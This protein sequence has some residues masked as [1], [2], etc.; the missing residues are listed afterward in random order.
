MSARA[1]SAIIVGAGPSGIAMAYKLKHELGFED[2]TIYDKMDGVGGTWR[3]NSYPGCGCDVQSTL[4]SFSFNL[5]PNWSK[6]LAEQEE[7]LQYIEDTVD[8]F[9][10]RPHINVSVECTGAKWDATK[11]E[12][13]V[14]LKDLKTG[15]NF[16]RCATM[17]ISAVG[18]ISVPR[19]VH[20]EGMEAFKGPI[21]HT[22]QWRHDV[23]YAGKRVAVI[24]NGCSAVQVVPALAEKATSV[25]QYAR[26]P[27]WYHERPNRQFTS[28]E[29]WAFRTFPLIMRLRR[30]N[31]FWTIDKQ[32][33]AYRGTE[34]GVA[35]RLKEE[36]VARQYIQSKAPKKYH[37]ILTPD[38]ELGCKRKIA[39]PGYLEAL[40][41]KNI[42]L[43]PEG[44]QRIT[45]KGII[46]SSGREDEYDIIILATG[47]KV[48]QFLTP[49]EITGADGNTLQQQWNECR[50]AQAYLGTFVHNFPN[51]AI[52]FGP[53]TFPANNSALYACE[54]QVDYACRALVKPI[55]DG[56]ANVLEVKETVENRTTNDIHLKLRNSVFAGKCTNWYIG[57]FGRNTA[58]W[59]GM[60][61][62]FWIAT[63]IPNRE[64]FISTGGSKI[65][66][67]KSFKRWIMGSSL[68][69]ATLSS[70]LAV[71]GLNKLG[72]LTEGCRTENKQYDSTAIAYLKWSGYQE[73]GSGIQIE[74]LNVGTT[75][76]TFVAA[77]TEPQQLWDTDQYRFFQPIT[78]SQ[79]DFRRLQRWLS[80][81]EEEH[82][83]YRGPRRALGHP[84]ALDDQASHTGLGEEQDLPQLHIA[85]PGLEI[86]RFIDVT[87]KCLVEKKQLHRYVTLSYVWGAVASFKLS[88]NNRSRLMQSGAIRD[89]WE[90]IPRTLQDAIELTEKLGE[91][92]LWIDSLCLVQND[93]NDV[94]SGTESMDLIYEKAVLTIVAAC[95]KD[96]NAG[97]PGVRPGSRFVSDRVVEVKPGLSLS[98]YTTLDY[99][100]APTMYHSRAWT[101]Q[102]YGLS[103][104]AVYFV[105]DRV[106]FRCQT[107]IHSENYHDQTSMK[108]KRIFSSPLSKALVMKHPSHD[109]K[110]VVEFYSRRVLTYP[111]DVENALTGIIRRFS[112]R[113]K[114][115]FLCGLPTAVFDSHLLFRGAA[116]TLKRRSGFPS[117]SWTG[118]IGPLLF[119]PI[120]FSAGV[121]DLN[122]HENVWLRDCTWIR[123]YKIRPS[124]LSNLVWDPRG[125]VD[126]PHESKA[127]PG[128]RR[129]LPFPKI[130]GL[131]VD[132]SITIPSERRIKK[133][134]L[135]PYPMLQFWSLV[136]FFKI[137]RMDV[138]KARGVL[139]DRF[140]RACGLLY[141][142]G[143]EE[144]NSL[145]EAEPLELVLL[146]EGIQEPGI[147]DLWGGE[148]PLDSRCY[149]V[150]HLEW[151]EGV[152]E[153]RGIG[154]LWPNAITRSFAPGP[155][156]KEIILG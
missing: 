11:W 120:K 115:R 106:Y 88:R 140:G 151:K 77:V 32:S 141:I 127:H 128:Y 50:G 24:G 111:E 40:N 47:F 116:M 89:V 68:I 45:D 75:N 107:S 144:M 19:E 86:I 146:S 61:I 14:H 22:A 82:A 104:R 8:K 109:F 113:M 153:R 30:W 63:L 83:C 126:F 49:M 130:A 28:F 29:K 17:F 9:Q 95:G 18:G 142:D 123:W 20:F 137:T 4:Y 35:Q 60:A 44:I 54:V 118:W 131:H 41:R 58:S 36:E 91:R 7:I 59:P 38:F 26:S 135:R 43:L 69:Y 125:N 74:F 16:T 101:L 152:A 138:F 84:G 48:S 143:Y 70:G 37:D 46:S 156:W 93:P 148:A 110:S 31:I 97:L 122:E 42:E 25:K 64:A 87:Q 21:Y 103:R 12:W 136:V 132:C 154:E 1:V 100:L 79:L 67:L 124:G 23:S 6:E 51:L 94:Q 73:P 78:K 52:L 92:Y 90:L 62:E 155:V 72:F 2:F 133:S 5:N 121:G 134:A 39:D 85:F 108:Y 114:C 65:W 149:H 112:N 96:A 119:L 66:F 57:D 129:H 102:E 139:E 3:A 117:Y 27:Q 147:D 10:L 13:R 150:L 33:Y 76:G 98:V 105:D 99:R 80:V 56:R 15:I 145:Q 71:Y 34:A 53:N 81:C 55:L